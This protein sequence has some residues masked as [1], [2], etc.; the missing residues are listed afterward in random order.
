M[1]INFRRCYCKNQRPRDR[2]RKRLHLE[3]TRR[4]PRVDIFRNGE[5]HIT[6]EEAL[7]LRNQLNRFNLEDA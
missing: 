5:I 7:R 4:Q 2:K 1:A 6:R 3:V